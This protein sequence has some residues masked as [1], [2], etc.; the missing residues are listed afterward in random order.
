MGG[1][2]LCNSAP[3]V[4]AHI[5]AM[6]LNTIP[7]QPAIQKALALA[8]AAQVL[9][10]LA[11]LVGYAGCVAWAKALHQ[12]G[13]LAKTIGCVITVEANSKRKQNCWQKWM[14]LGAKTGC[15]QDARR[16]FFIRGYQFPIC[17]RCT[18]ILL[19]NT[20]GILFSIFFPSFWWS[21]CFF[22]PVAVDG[23]TQY[24]G[25]RTS[26]NFLRFTTGLVAGFGNAVF[27]IWIFSLVI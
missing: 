25:W 15:H 20:I 3:A 6:L 16:S 18:G 23:I 22:L 11:G 14:I 9:F 21:C 7:R 8:K 4:V 17:T 5:C 10:Y 2:Y 27:C 24:L 19:G 12:Q 1:S 26:N 13:R